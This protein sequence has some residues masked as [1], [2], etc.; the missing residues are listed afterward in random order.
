MRPQ[1]RVRNR[2][3]QELDPCRALEQEEAT[4]L[5][6]PGRATRSLTMLSLLA[7][8]SSLLRRQHLDR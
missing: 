1:S 7:G 2:S 6:T 5:T 3:A 4:M 8:R